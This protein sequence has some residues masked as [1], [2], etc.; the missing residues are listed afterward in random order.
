MTIPVPLATELLPLTFHCALGATVTVSKLE[1]SVPSPVSVPMLAA[2]ASSNRA[3][4]PVTTVPSNTAP[5]TSTSRSL[6]V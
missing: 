5:G 2:E 3:L 6:P 4:P 1:K